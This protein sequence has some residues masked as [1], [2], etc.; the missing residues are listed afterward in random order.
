[1]TSEEIDKFEKIEMC[2][3]RY[4]LNNALQKQFNWLIETNTT[5]LSMWYIGVSYVPKNIQY[6][7]KK[8][9]WN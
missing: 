6:I 7:K 8:N 5:N 9:K 1:M 3:I 4:F 2:K